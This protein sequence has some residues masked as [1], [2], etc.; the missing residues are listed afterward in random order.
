MTNNPAKL[1]GLS[2]YG[3]EIAKRMKIRPNHNE[4]NAFYLKTKQ[5]KMGHMLAF[6][7][8]KSA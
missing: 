8:K 3:I 4:V 2:G 5:H 6:D 1:H 7:K